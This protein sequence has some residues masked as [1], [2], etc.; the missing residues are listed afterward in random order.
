MPFTL[1]VQ[2]QRQ[3]GNGAWTACA[4][5]QAKR[6]AVLSERTTG[7][8]VA[9]RPVKQV[10]QH[11]KFATKREAYE[12]LHRRERADSASRFA[13]KPASIGGRMPGKPAGAKPPL[14]SSLSLDQYLMLHPRTKG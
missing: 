14:A 4:E 1:F 7:H 3:Q 6:W 8:K 2:P 5:H 12:D 13:P 9:G 10:V 11:A